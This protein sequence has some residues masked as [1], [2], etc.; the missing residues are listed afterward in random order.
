MW[1]L[2][3]KIIDTQTSILEND[4]TDQLKTY[5]I[6]LKTYLAE[7]K[8]EEILSVNEI[9]EKENEIITEVLTWKVKC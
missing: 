6:L 7:A 4:I 9:L 3:G 1:N 5:N 2:S 8:D